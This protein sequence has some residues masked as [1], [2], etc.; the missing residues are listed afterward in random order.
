MKSIFPPF[1]ISCYHCPPEKPEPMLT[2]NEFKMYKAIRKIS[3]LIILIVKDVT[4]KKVF[5]WEDCQC[6][7]LF[8]V[9]G[10]LYL[11]HHS[12]EKMNL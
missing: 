2:P 9:N 10:L 6:T 5:V 1:V 3:K 4:F 8:K 7:Y 12:G 11:I